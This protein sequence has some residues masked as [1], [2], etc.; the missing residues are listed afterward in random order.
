MGHRR[1]TAS[2]VE[3][4]TRHLTGGT[5]RARLLEEK[6]RNQVFAVGEQAIFKAYLA[7]GAAK[8]VRKIAALEFL[9]GRGLPVP[10]LLGHGIL[11]NGDSG[12]P[13]TLETRV[14]AEHARPSRGDLDTPW[15]WEL[16]RALG[17]WLPTLH[18]FGGFP[19]FGTW[20][21]DGPAT[22]AGHVL[23]RARA[24]RAQAADL[25]NVPPALMRRALLEL[26]RLEPA[27]MEA[28]WLR[29]RLLHGDYGT[30]NAAAGPA[31]GGGREVV[32]VFD[33]ES[34]APGDPV[35]D[36]LWN[37]DHG[38][39]SPIFQSFLAG[40]HE[41]DQLDP[42]APER[43]AFYQLE[44][45]LAILGWAHQGYPE[46]FAQALWLIEQELGGARLPLA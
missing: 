19:S 43:F 36:F 20:Q 14:I 12:V 1:L 22:L 33:F 27:I 30:S 32:A 21:A 8:Q 9:A 11:P 5:A 15:G 46:Y 37:A 4:A 28:G 31:A 23:P 41:H 42:G 34:A 40:Y 7:D 17:R 2:E 26:E 18:A 44:H 6:D 29:P 16:H 13:W 25:D 3:A 35:E 38:L 39:D 45:C 24:A 10:R